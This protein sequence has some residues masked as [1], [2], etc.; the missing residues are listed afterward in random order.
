MFDIVRVCKF[1][2]Y[3]MEH[4]IDHGGS[5]SRDKETQE[6]ECRICGA[7]FKVTVEV[8]TKPVRAVVP[9]STRG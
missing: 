8:L 6:V 3:P 2:K 4:P 1:C 7:H 9:N 5:F